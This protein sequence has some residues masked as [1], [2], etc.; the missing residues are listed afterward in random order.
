MPRVLWI[1]TQEQIKNANMTRF[2]QYVN[3]KH[4]KNFVTYPELYD[5]SIKSIPD[6]WAAMWEFGDIVHSEPYDSVVT[7]LD[8]MPGAIWFAGARLNYA[9]N[10]LR[11]RD[12]RVAIVFRGETKIRRTFTYAEL[13]HRVAGLARALR[14]AGIKTGD[15]VAGFMPN[16]PEAI[17]AMLATTSIGAIWSSCSPDFGIKGVLDRFGQIEP[18]ILFTADGYFYKDKSFNSLEKIAG[19]IGNLP[20]VEK[21]IVIPYTDKQPDIASLPNAVLIDD[22]YCKEE[23][24]EIQF[25]QLPFDHPLYIMY[26]SGTTGVPKCIV[27]GAGGTL[28]QHLKELVL[29]TDLKRDDNIFYFTTCGWMMWNWLV[30]SLAVGA[31]L[32]LF[33]G[34]PFYPDAYALFNI[35]KEENMTVF[36]TSAKYIA[37]V[38]GA[39]VKLGQGDIPTVRAMLSTGSPLS[40]EN[41]EF[42]YR[43]IK[44]DIMLSSISGGTDII[45]C[46]ALGN[47]IGPV[48]SG[49][50]QCRGL[51]MRV[52]AF[53]DSGSPIFTQQ[54]ELVCTAPFPSMP[55]YFWNDPEDRKYRAAYFE[56]YPNIWHH[57][58]FVVITE[59]GGVVIYGR[60]DA[61]LNPGGVRIG[62]AEIYNVVENIPEI[63]DSLVVG[64]DWDNDVRVLLFVKMKTGIELSEELINT[65]R[66]SIRTNTTPRHVPA[67]V[68]AVADIPYTINGKKVE[69][70]VK[71]IIHGQE[72]K[73]KDALGNPESLVLYQNLKELQE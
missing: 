68:L 18:K 28:I 26:S 38:E 1:P 53:D 43:Q 41:F 2:I 15:R 16:M 56:R 24:L 47:P 48:I 37:S 34:N 59:E 5:W 63:E 39:G 54:G 17:I 70:A 31:T 42:V 29:H 62:T 21:I 51:G 8:K 49:E 60:S 36:G 12:D 3:N 7:D 35:A 64:Q 55:I 40:Q 65:I 73:N 33:D 4:G 20:S 52:L 6:F 23:G 58:D 45:S 57:G 27:H 61:T 44:K 71:K 14:E 22:F 30:S 32:L 46:F 67:K 69:L 25:E 66:T 9:E 11:H 13:Y 19:I 50:L 10:L 72:V